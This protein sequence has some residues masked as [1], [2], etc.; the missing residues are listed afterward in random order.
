[1][2]WYAQSGTL[3]TR[4]LLTDAAVALWTLLWVRLGAAVHDAVQRL[5]APGRELEEAGRGL[6]GGLSTAAD[7]AD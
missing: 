4:Q 7:Q 2:R 3:R 5:G 1:M 6:S